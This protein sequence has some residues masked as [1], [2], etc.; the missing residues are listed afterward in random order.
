LLVTA[1]SA[2]GYL[3]F[4]QVPSLDLMMSLQ[5]QR[6]ASAVVI[7]AID[8]AAFESL[9]RRQ[10]LSRAYLAK[11]LRALHRSG[12]AV[13]GLDVALTSPTTPADD[14]ALVQAILD[15]SQTGQPLVLAEM[16]G[17]DSGPLADPTFLRAVVRGSPKIPSTTMA[18]SAGRF[19]CHP[20]RLLPNRPSAWPLLHDWQAWKQSALE[21]ILDQPHAKVSP[22]LAIWRRLGPGR[23]L[24]GHY[25]LR[26]AMA[27]QLRR[28]AKSFLTIPSGTVCPR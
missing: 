1:A 14:A 23:G 21:K 26:R 15:F 12:A 7:V 16:A 13:V 24:T 18:S 25:A 28:P 3:E 17:P 19:S 5:G 22:C 2:K 9:G 4:L 20:P 11:L 6:F 10:P 8:D 27:H